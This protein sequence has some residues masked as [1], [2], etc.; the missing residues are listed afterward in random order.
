MRNKPDGGAPQSADVGEIFHV[1]PSRL[2]HRAH[3]SAFERTADQHGI[4]LLMQ[5]THAVALVH[6]P[7]L[8]GDR[9]PTS[10]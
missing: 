6:G 10:E 4:Q 8:A 3:V 5:P 2:V 7:S 1:L 9:T